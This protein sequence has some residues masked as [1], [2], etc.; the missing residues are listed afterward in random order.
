MECGVI[1]E[2]RPIVKEV[3]ALRINAEDLV[4][5][6]AVLRERIKYFSLVSPQKENCEKPPSPQRSTLEEDLCQVNQI[7]RRAKE[8]LSNITGEIR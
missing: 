8:E 1:S 5:G 3:S 7:L 2:E 4:K 6:I